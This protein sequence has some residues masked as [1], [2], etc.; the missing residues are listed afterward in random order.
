MALQSLSAS[1]NVYAAV[2]R[3]ARVAQG[4][5]ALPK[6]APFPNERKKETA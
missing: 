2:D 5:R 3:M 1:A 6:V 4:R